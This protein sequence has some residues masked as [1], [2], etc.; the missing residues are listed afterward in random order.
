MSRW[1][2]PDRVEPRRRKPSPRTTT[3]TTHV[4]RPH[5]A[6]LTAVLGM[7]MLCT[8]GLVS[9][10]P[11]ASPATSP[12]VRRP[13]SA[14]LFI[15]EYM[16]NQ[17]VKVRGRSQTTVPTTGLTR[18]TGTVLDAERNLYVS[19]T[20]NNRVV[21]V[22]AD[23]SGQTTVP[24]TGLSR[25]LGLALDRSGNLYIADS[26]N[27]RV[28]K[29]PADGGP[30]T[31]VPTTG[32][33]HPDGLA[34]DRA[35]N[36]YIADFVNDR[37][38]KVPAGGGPQ[39]T[40]PTT[41]LSQPTGLA[42][43]ARTLYIADSGHDRVLRVRLNGG[44][45]RT[46]PTTGLNSPQGLALDAARNLYIADFGNDRVLKVP[47][48]GGR[49]T[50]VPTTGLS[51]PVGLAILGQRGR[52]RLAARTATEQR[53]FFP[54][55]LRVRGLSATL[56][57]WGGTPLPG[58]TVTFTDT[59]KTRSLCTAVTDARGVAR[60]DAVVRTGFRQVNRLYR[61]LR[62]HGYLARFS[63]TTALRPST[64]IAPVLPRR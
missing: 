62:R 37:V 19:D 21:K 60:C 18:P 16:T 52:T 7:V 59:A 30:Q 61:D 36:L 56:T 58:R 20:G 28:V 47:A 35:G 34:F 38:V 48:G 55:E 57:R 49:Q 13:G 3:T 43:R 29:V 6:R 25:P 24:A 63:G 39:T 23:G 32:L 51:T 5:H 8:A 27:D 14:P 46:V 45:Q 41:G 64:D 9:A 50:T 2:A 17:V 44:Q 54:A 12:A 10:A 1:K 15:S 53:R 26:F 42:V 31:T 22:P 4:R 11:A 40:V 33:T